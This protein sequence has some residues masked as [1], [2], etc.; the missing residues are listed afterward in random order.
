MIYLYFSGVES[1]GASVLA[2]AGGKNAG[3]VCASAV[4]EK[5][6][7][8]LRSLFSI[9]TASDASCWLCI[10]VYCCLNE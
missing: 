7:S 6:V 4:T 8:L 3:E 2:R 1:K 5:S 9:I 10:L